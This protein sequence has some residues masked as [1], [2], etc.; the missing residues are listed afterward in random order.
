MK[1]TGRGVLLLLAGFFGVIFATNAVFITAAVKSFRGEDEQKPYLQGIE[2]NETL[3]RRSQQARLGWIASLAAHRLPSGA[4]LVDAWVQGR[5][6]KGQDHLALAGELRHP[7]DENRDQQLSFREVAAGH[8]EARL[9]TAAP[10]HWDVIVTN[11]GRE[12]F[13]ASRRLWLR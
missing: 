13:Q 4:V 10:G 2:Y 12:P 1:L 7:S 3:E 9:A 5:D 6:G 8:Y 11:Q